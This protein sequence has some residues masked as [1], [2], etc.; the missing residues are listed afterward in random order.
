MTK[1]SSFEHNGKVDMTFEGT[2]AG[3]S[4]RVV[5]ENFGQLYVFPP[6]H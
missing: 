1:G 2:R 6:E 4:F 3:P 5:R